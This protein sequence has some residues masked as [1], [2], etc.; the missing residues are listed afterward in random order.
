LLIYFLALQIG[1]VAQV[2]LPSS[3][4]FMP[5]AEA[6]LGAQQ[7]FL[8]MA[9]PAQKADAQTIR[10]SSFK[11]FMVLFLVWNCPRRLIRDNPSKRG[12]TAEV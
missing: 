6:A 7:S 2:V 4:H 3:Q 8:H 9:Q 10:A 1:Q 5:H 12:D 11:D